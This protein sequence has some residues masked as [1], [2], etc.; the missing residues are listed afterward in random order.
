MAKDSEATKD[1]KPGIV[2]RIKRS[3]KKNGEKGSRKKIL[4]ELFYDLNRSRAQIYK[5]NF[6]RGL[7]FGA[8]T[9]IGG[10][11][12]IALLVWLLTFL[13]SFI[14]PLDDFFNSITRILKDSAE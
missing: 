14:P 2:E 1:A 11:L 9:V 12:V 3:V 7:F 8:G 6:V 10:T 13:G 5:L 4:E